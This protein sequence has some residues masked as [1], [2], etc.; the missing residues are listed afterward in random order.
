MKLFFKIL[1]IVLSVIVIYLI[2]ANLI[3]FIISNFMDRIPAL[4]L[5]QFIG[6]AL[7]VIFLITV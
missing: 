7:V 2:S 1:K 4:M 5:S 6:I 3:F